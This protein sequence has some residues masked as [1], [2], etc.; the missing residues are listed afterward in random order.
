MNIKHDNREFRRKKLLRNGKVLYNKQNVKKGETVKLL[1]YSTGGILIEGKDN[2][3]LQKV[4][5]DSPYF[6][7]RFMLHRSGY[8]MTV[9]CKMI[10]KEHENGSLRIGAKFLL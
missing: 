8:P 2:G 9:E 3:F 4:T 5:E 10:R 6:T 1:N 7:L